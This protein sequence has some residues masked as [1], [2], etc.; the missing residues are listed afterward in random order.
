[1]YMSHHPRPPSLRG[2]QQQLGPR[3]PVQPTSMGPRALAS[4][5][6]STNGDGRGQHAPSLTESAGALTESAR[7]LTVS[8]PLLMQLEDGGYVYQA[9]GGSPRL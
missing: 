7:A 9:A 6:P 8:V 5:A 2:A 1:M 3:A 4:P